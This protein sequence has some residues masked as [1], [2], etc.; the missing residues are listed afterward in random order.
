MNG[1]YIY[2]KKFWQSTIDYCDQIWAIKRQIGAE[3]SETSAFFSTD[4]GQYYEST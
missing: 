4:H 1:S 2:S 3:L